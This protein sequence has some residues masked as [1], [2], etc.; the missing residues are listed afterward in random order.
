MLAWSLL[1]WQQDKDNRSAN[2]YLKG[3]QRFIIVKLATT[4]PTSLN[5][6]IAMGVV[7]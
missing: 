5:S 7:L 1:N 3:K 4:A 6:K 2:K